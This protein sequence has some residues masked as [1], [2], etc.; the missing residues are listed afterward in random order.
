[1]DNFNTGNIQ[2]QMDAA[3]AA[4]I[5]QQ[6]QTQVPTVSAQTPDTGNW[7]THMLP[8]IGSIAAPIIGGLATGGT[9]LLAG[10]ALSGAGGAAGQALQNALEG[11]DVGNN[12]VESG[13]TN[14]AGGLA[15]GLLGKIGSKFAANAISPVA[16]NVADKLISGQAVK[17]T[18]DTNAANLL[19]TKFGITDISQAKKIAD[20]ATGTK[21]AINQ[22]TLRTVANAADNGAVADL[23]NLSSVGKNLVSENAMQLTPTSVK[24]ISEKIQQSLID[25]VH[26]ESVTKIPGKGGNIV[27]N[28]DNGAL[29]N[30]L[31]ENALKISK[32][33]SK[34]AESA[35]NAAYDKFGNVVNADQAAK[36][37]VF[38][39]LANHAN[40][41]AFAS[42]PVTLANKAEIIAGLEPIKSINPTSYNALVKQVSEAKIGSDLRSIQ[43]PLVNASKAV[44]ATEKIASQTGA[45]AT[46]ILP[47]GAGAGGFMLGGPG[48]GLAGYAAGKVL[49]SKPTQT[50]AASLLNKLS[51]AAGSSTAQ[52]VIP[53]LS[54]I[55]ASTAVNAPTMGAGPV[56]TAGQPQL[57]GTMQGTP[58][59]GVS[60]MVATQPTAAQTPYD[61]LVSAMQ[62]QSILAPTMAGQ[63]GATNF[64]QGIAPQLQAKQTLGGMLGNMQTAYGN[65]GGAQGLGGAFS[66]LSSLVPGTAANTYQQQQQAVAAQL[67]N[68]MGI[69]KEEALAMLPQLMQ[70]SQEANQRMGGLQ[71]VLSSLA[72]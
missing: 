62:A 50:A 51:N 31:P 14:A 4:K 21:G 39:G 38:K 11:K 29:A 13:L 59:P 41:Q 36:Y 63:S 58:V 56:S 8:T 52:K 24:Q 32:T 6:Q 68:S 43:A 60:G 64:L 71:S 34:L 3:N 53:T 66:M 57:G 65:A 49:E 48:G 18:L 28:I 42:S 9:G 72:G 30:A 2:Q 17:G 67:A 37:N 10:A 25:S 12:L 19:R 33:Y 40:E 16:G 45:K 70:N 1:M 47:M 22:G 55:G 27:T 35:K 5:S 69:T 15:G 20:I 46:D 54:R 7:F 26:P 61:Q 23:S 44:G